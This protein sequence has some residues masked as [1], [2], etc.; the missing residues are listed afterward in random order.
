MFFSTQVVMTYL[1]AL[2]FL[3]R[4]PACVL[5]WSPLVYGFNTIWFVGTEDLLEALFEIF[6]EESIE[7]WIDAGVEVGEDDDDEVDSGVGHRDD[8]DQV[9]HVGDEEGQ[10]ADEKHQHHDHHHARD[11]TL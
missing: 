6:G 1:Q 5:S 11:L 2:C 4:V 10:P 7:E 8:V 9:D 3:C